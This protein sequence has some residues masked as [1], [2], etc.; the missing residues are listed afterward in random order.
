MSTQLAGVVSGAI[1]ERRFAAAE[2]GS[3]LVAE[4]GQAALPIR[5]EQAERIP[6]LLAPGVS[7]LAALQHDVVDPA[8]AEATAHCEARVACADDHC[9]NATDCSQPPML[10]QRFV[11]CATAAPVSDGVR[12]ACP[13]E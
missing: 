1:D 9:G 7:N 12:K 3:A 2:E 10:R 4:G 8:V 11:G 5:R 13:R 6:A